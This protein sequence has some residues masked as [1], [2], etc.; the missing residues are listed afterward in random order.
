MSLYSSASRRLASLRAPA[1]A[2]AAPGPEAAPRRGFASSG[3]GLWRSYSKA[4]ETHPMAVKAV[5]SGAICGAGDAACQVVHSLAVPADGKAKLSFDALR[6]LRFTA[7]G[8]VLLAPM[9]HVWYGKLSAW[10]PGTSTASVRGHEASAQIFFC[11]SGKHALLPHSLLLLFKRGW[12]FEVLQAHL[13]SLARAQALRCVAPILA[14]PALSSSLVVLPRRALWSRWPSGAEAHGLGPVRLCAML[15]PVLYVERHAPRGQGG[16]NP[17]ATA[18]LL[19]RRGAGQLGPLDPRAGPQLQIHPPG[20]PG[21]PTQ[22]AA[23]SGCA[24]VRVP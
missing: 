12:C 18:R 14:P 1:A 4:L 15:H 7:V 22:R 23:A 6:T 5:T 2:W 16:R 20:L 19:G 9:L 21:E 8:S 13:L 3:G 24:F 10:I 11:S 17:G